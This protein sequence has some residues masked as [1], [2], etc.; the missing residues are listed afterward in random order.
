MAGTLLF[1]GPGQAQAPV[2]IVE[3]VSSRSAGVE[4]MD[5]VPVGTRVPLQGNDTLTLGYLKSCW[6]ESIVGGTVLVGPEQSEVKGGTVS[7]TKEQCDGGQMQLTPEQANKSG[8]M[9]FRRPPK[10]GV[11]KTAALEPSLMLYGRTPMFELGQSGRLS[12]E[13]LDQ[14]AAAITID[15]A[16]GQLLR[17]AFFDLAKTSTLLA[18]GG[19][20]RASLNGRQ[21]VFKIAASATPGA[22]PLLGRLVRLQSSQ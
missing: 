9:A 21:V 4:F 2:A 18:A 20:Y 13:R 14:T 3:D 22:T 19:V 12:I 6:R 5:Y 16:H 10:L 11:G 7:R 1:A 8:A 17:G 15:V